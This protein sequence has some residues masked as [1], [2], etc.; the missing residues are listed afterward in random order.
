[1]IPT[2]IIESRWV[3]AKPTERMAYL[4]GLLEGLRAAGAGKRIA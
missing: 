4:E 3:D 1:M 2:I